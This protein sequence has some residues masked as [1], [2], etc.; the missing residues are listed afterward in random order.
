[1]FSNYQFNTGSRVFLTERDG[2]RFWA[3]KIEQHLQHNFDR[4]PPVAVLRV[5]RADVEHLLRPDAVGT[6]DARASCYYIETDFK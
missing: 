6:K 3:W 4:P 2:V 5:H 1:M